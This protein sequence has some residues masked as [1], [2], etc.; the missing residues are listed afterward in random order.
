MKL[1]VKLLAGLT[2]ALLLVM[3][4]AGL[5]HSVSAEDVWSADPTTLSAADFCDDPTDTGRYQVQHFNINGVT[6]YIGF[7][8]SCSGWD[9]MRLIAVVHG[10]ESVDAA[11]LE[12]VTGNRGKP[13]LFDPWATHVSA[14]TP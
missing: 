9:S 8:T 3:A 12:W 14:Y 11:A 10:Y 7:T 13:W 4:I 1:S 5:S 2:L 6:D